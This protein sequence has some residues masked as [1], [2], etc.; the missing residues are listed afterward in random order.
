M[1]GFCLLMGAFYEMQVQNK[2]RQ[3]QYIHTFAASL[4]RWPALN[5]VIPMSHH[6]CC[7]LKGFV[8]VVLGKDPRI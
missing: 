3:V 7:K 6:C 1:R 2:G 5:A 8:A 4:V